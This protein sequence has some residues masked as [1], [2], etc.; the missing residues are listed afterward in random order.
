MESN[1]KFRILSL[2]G[3]GIRGAY[4]AALLTAIEIT[5]EKRIVDHFDL[6]VVLGPREVSDLDLGTGDNCND[7]ALDFCG[8]DHEPP[9]AQ[10]SLFDKSSSSHAYIPTS[11]QS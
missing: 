4:A 7:A 10:C 2:D 5:T 6:V 3:G 8:L 1:A 11:K 9:L